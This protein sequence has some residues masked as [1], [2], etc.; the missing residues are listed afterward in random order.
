M[1]DRFTTRRATLQRR[2]QQTCKV[3]SIKIDRSHLS[4]AVQSRCGYVGDRDI[5]SALCIEAEGMKRVPTDYREF[6]PGETSTSTFFDT[7]SKIAGVMASKLELRSQE[8][9]GLALR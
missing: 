3:Y 9:A 1:G 4:V 6:K 7:V 5:K 2:K 8:A